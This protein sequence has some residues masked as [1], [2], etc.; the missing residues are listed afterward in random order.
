MKKMFFAPLGIVI[1]VIILTFLFINCASL[2]SNK[3][4]TVGTLLEE[5]YY[6][7]IAPNISQV[8]DIS[9]NEPD[10]SGLVHQDDYS[11]DTIPDTSQMYENLSKEE[12]LRLAG[13]PF[14]YEQPTASQD[15]FINISYKNISNEAITAIIFTVVCRNHGYLQ[16]F[17]LID[18]DVLYP[19]SS[20]N[21]QWSISGGIYTSEPIK[22]SDIE[23]VFANDKKWK[24]TKGWLGE[25]WFG[26]EGEGL[27]GREGVYI[28]RP[29][30]EVLK[31]TMPKK[32][33]YK[34][35][36]LGMFIAMKIP[37]DSTRYF[38]KF[39][40]DAYLAIENSSS[41]V[42]SDDAGVICNAQMSYDFKEKYRIQDNSD[43]DSEKKYR[44]KYTFAWMPDFGSLI[45]AINIGNEEYIIDGVTIDEIDNLLTY[46]EAHA[47]QDK[48]KEDQKIRETM[49]RHAEMD[50]AYEAAVRSQG[51]DLLK[52]YITTYI[53]DDYFNDDSYLEI[54][55]KITRN[56]NAILENLY[57]APNPYGFNED[58]VYYGGTLIVTQ[59]LDRKIVAYTNYSR[60]DE[61]IIIIDG[62]PDI[63]K[64]GS[65]IQHSFLQYTGTV[66]LQFNSRAI[67]R[68]T[69]RLL[70]HW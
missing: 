45:G 27:N 64:I 62:F 52:E 22:I 36:G 58:V 44:I 30:R 3:S 17:E 65:S 24:L 10:N 48:E 38:Y 31:L 16:E 8:Q 1:T 42:I 23:I 56:N 41:L 34:T 53:R 13:T 21:S 61:N 2:E 59:W 6:P 35:A 32:D 68:P 67:D 63:T 15:S 28:D 69:F 25:D 33:A 46:A 18:D 26:P 29:F 14:F 55:K 57:T 7:V 11:S 66:K 40:S 70:Y 54:A 19:N 37:G 47:K 49:A 51:V 39:V 4:Q 43:F 50:R 5:N 60:D 20:T 12:E 9:D